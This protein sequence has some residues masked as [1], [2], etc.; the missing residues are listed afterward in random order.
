MERIL[1]SPILT[2]DLTKKAPRFFS[3]PSKKNKNPEWRLSPPG[4]LFSYVLA[5]T[6]RMDAS[7]AKKEA[8][9]TKKSF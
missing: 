5:L 2:P 6:N 9:E 7:K 1:F 8:S 3:G 4:V